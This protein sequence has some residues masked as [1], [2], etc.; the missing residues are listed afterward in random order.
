[1]GVWS[2]GG[3]PVVEVWAAA[4]SISRARV[5]LDEEDKGR[6]RMTRVEKLTVD[7]IDHA[8]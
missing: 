8:D 1:L 7:K 5:G 2:K 3:Y 4:D 6:A